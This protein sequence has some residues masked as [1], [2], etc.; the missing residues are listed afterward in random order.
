[1]TFLTFAVDSL[2]YAPS[3]AVFVASV[4]GSKESDLKKI[5]FESDKV[6]SI[7]RNWQNRRWIDLKFAL[8]HSA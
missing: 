8:T 1:L 5:L 7:I 4:V 3:R 2:F 6:D